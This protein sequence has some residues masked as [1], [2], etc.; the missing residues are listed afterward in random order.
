MCYFYFSFPYFYRSAFNAKPVSVLVIFYVVFSG[1]AFFSA[2]NTLGMF[3]IKVFIV[4][5][6][7]PAQFITLTANFLWYLT[8]PML[9]NFA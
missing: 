7:F 3:S 4:I 6:F 8:Y 2:H 5:Q 1:Y 9:K